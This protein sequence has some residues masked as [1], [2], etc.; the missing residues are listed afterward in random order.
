[1]GWL[2]V[3]PDVCSQSC[4]KRKWRRTFSILKSKV[5]RTALNSVPLGKSM[6][7][8]ANLSIIK[9]KYR[10]VYLC[11]SKAWSLNP[12]AKII[13]SGII[14]AIIQ[15]WTN[16]LKDGVWTAEGIRFMRKCDG[17]LRDVTSCFW[18]CPFVT[19]RLF[20]VQQRQHDRPAHVLQKVSP[21]KRIPAQLPFSTLALLF[22]SCGAVAST[23]SVDLPFS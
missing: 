13:T 2:A 23:F 21:G 20:S 7:T 14:V 17:V 22:L 1:M 8:R 19:V 15:R 11:S 16:P 9:K 10:E 3:Y 5:I 4:E 12:P 6:V 18:M